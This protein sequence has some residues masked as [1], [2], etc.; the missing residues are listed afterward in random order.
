LGTKERRQREVA[1]R[2]K[3]FIDKARELVCAE[4]LL[5]LQMARLAG[6]CDYATGTLYQHFGSKE[7]LVVALLTDRIE[8]RTELFRRAADWDARPRDRMFAVA[9]ADTLFVQ[10]NPEYFRI[11]QLALTEVVWS[12]ASVERRQAY[13][14]KMKPIGD[15]VVGIVNA[16]VDAGDLELEGGATVEE[17]ALGVWTLVC[18]THTLVHAEGFLESFEVHDPYRLMGRNIH[19]LLN[20]LA[21]QPLF[22]VADSGAYDK[23]LERLT[24]LFAEDVRA[25]AIA[26]RRQGRGQREKALL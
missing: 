19:R 10:R 5:Q 9:A 7:D 11:A 16:A 22:D 3:L 21:W 8:Q 24:E 12:A 6:E 13:L 15:I 17:A 25:G 4:G 26:A 18:G 1:E 14:T 23:Y 2:E 20:G